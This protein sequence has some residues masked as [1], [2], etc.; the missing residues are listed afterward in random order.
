MTGSRRRRSLGVLTAGLLGAAALAGCSSEVEGNASAGSPDPSSSSSS[1]PSSSSAGGSTGPLDDVED[2]SAGLLPADAF[3]AGA[4]ATPMTTDEFEQQSEL[5]GLGLGD[6]TITPEACAPAV[7]QVQPG[8][9]DMVGLGAQTVAVGA[10]A[11][12]EI[13]AEG[14]GFTEGIE[15]LATTVETCPQATITAPQI[16]TAT[17]AFT[18]LDVPELGDGS[19]G[20]TMTLTLPGPDGQPLTVPVLLAMAADG[21]RLVS[22]TATD[23]TGVSDPAAFVA[24]MQQA[25]DHQA[26]ALD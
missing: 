21:E 23:P 2:L 13:L 19:A 25:F 18:A 16:G 5:G 26:T 12:V 20:V 9:E 3:G 11:V 22:L 15:Q 17:V 6:V 10:G 8:L 1:S 14:P 7:E 4:R 24:L